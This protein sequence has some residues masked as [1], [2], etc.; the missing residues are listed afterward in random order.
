M[1]DATEA[2]RIKFFEAAH[3]CGSNPVS[4]ENAILSVGNEFLPACAIAV[5]D[6]TA[7]PTAEYWDFLRSQTETAQAEHDAEIAAGY[8]SSDK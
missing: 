7:E 2:A 5:R 8:E 3:A 4:E 6:K 1:N